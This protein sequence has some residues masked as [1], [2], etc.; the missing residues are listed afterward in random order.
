[1]NHKNY[2]CF[3]L[4]YKRMQKELNESK[5]YS[6][7]LHIIGQGNAKEASTIFYETCIQRL[8]QQGHD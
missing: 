4:F 1:M 5:N 3:Y 6:R 2:R 7:Q 8:T